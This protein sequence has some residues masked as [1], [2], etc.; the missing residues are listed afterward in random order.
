MSIGGMMKTYPAYGEKRDYRPIELYHDGRYI[1]TTTWAISLKQAK[2]QLLKRYPYF[3]EDKI[4]AHFL[5]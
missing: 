1:G 3:D 5:N 2:E 4:T